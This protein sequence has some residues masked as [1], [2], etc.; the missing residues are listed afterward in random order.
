MFFFHALQRFQDHLPDSHGRP[1]RA[2]CAP[3]RPRRRA[4]APQTKK[5]APPTRLLTSLREFPDD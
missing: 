2:A 4:A 3:T 5:Q 1:D